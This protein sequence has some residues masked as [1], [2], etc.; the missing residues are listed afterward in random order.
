MP[1]GHPLI[2]S[3]HRV[4]YS[5][6]NPPKL[7][8]PTWVDRAWDAYDRLPELHFGINV[9]SN[10]A[11]R[12]DYFPA[13]LPDPTSEP[14]RLEDGPVVDWLDNEGGAALL[15]RLVSS[16]IVHFDVP[17]LAYLVSVDE[18]KRRLWDIYS[19]QELRKE[20][21]DTQYSVTDN[22]GNPLQGEAHINDADVYVVWRPHPR[23]RTQAD[24]PL[25]ASLEVA[26][27]LVLVG[28]ERRAELMSRLSAGMLLLPDSMDLGGDEDTDEGDP[29]E[30]FQRRLTEVLTQ[31]IKDPGA[32]SAVV[33]FVITAAAEDIEK[34]KLQTFS[35]L[36]QYERSQGEQ[37]LI[38]R[39]ANGLDL[40][41]EI[42][43]GL[44]DTN[45]WSAWLVSETAVTQ[46]VDPT[47]RTIL[48]SLTTGWFHPLLQ[49]NQID[50][51]GVVLWRDITPAIVP[52]DRTGQH[53]D[54]LQNGV[55]GFDAVRE[56]LGYDDN[57]APT[58]A[59]LELLE[60]IQGTNQSAEVLPRG[61]AQSDRP[62][63][64]IAA[65]P[66]PSPMRLTELADLDDTN[67]EYTLTQCEAAADRVLEKVASRLRSRVQGNDKL[68][69]LVGDAPNSELIGMLAGRFAPADVVKPEDFDSVIA[70]IR[71]RWSRTVNATN[72]FLSR[73]VEAEPSTVTVEQDLDAGSH[74]LRN[75]LVAAVT[76]L[77]FTPD[78]KPDPV[79]EG[80]IRD[81]RLPVSEIRQAVSVAGGGEA[82]TVDGQVW[83][84]IGNG[85]RTDR[86]LQ[87]HG[88]ASL[89]FEWR[90]GDPAS[91]VT[92][93]EPHARLGGA[94]F[95]SWQDPQL[96]VTPDGDWVG[97]THYRPGDHRGCLCTYV[98]AI[99]VSLPIAAS[100]R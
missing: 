69:V 90:Y 72:S 35:R 24:S 61:P 28:R 7:A 58:E 88:M 80:E 3:A 52:A 18:E 93:F 66:G 32:A 17:G 6:T 16:L 40:P 14:E 2:A 30:S 9:R 62:A 49:A 20:V 77:L 89:S 22:S 37:Q 73:L 76:A 46:H 75:I 43:L 87:D 55:I 71:A 57:E 47:V 38:R 64:I 68:A 36:N 10:I 53:F 25:R 99:S 98:R 19:T 33:P 79:D 74:R 31:P 5:R 56:R 26:E 100:V 96:S 45:H 29:V 83:E 12:F 95:E 84:L 44:A 60:R 63:A 8:D 15:R 59:D 13:T 78:G 94:V 81:Q 54:A 23:D 4:R 48:D 70:R 50:T 92:N 27:Q 11:N 42:L 41:A 51:Q 21:G 91:R 86:T 82:S 67:L 97:G 39:L 1:I 34:V 65:L 85:Y